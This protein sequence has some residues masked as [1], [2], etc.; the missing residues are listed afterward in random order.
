MALT[1]ANGKYYA[2]SDCKFSWLDLT[3][4]VLVL[5]RLFTAHK[6]TSLADY[7]LKAENGSVQQKIL[8]NNMDMQNSFT[9]FKY[10]GQHVTQNTNEKYAFF[11]V[12]KSGKVLFPGNPDKV[13]YCKSEFFC[14][15]NPKNLYCL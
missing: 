11:M 2:I 15:Q 7:F 10:F 3:I 4:I 8:E 5:S 13:I 12:K 1:R 6:G 9:R 14:E